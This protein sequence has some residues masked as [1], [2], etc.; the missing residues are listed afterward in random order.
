MPVWS[1]R[2]PRL[3]PRLHPQRPPSGCRARLRHEAPGRKPRADNTADHYV[4][5]SVSSAD[6]FCASDTLTVT[7]GEPG[8]LQPYDVVNFTP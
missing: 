6:T 4:V 3:E 2:P 7:P 1:H 5:V 8:L